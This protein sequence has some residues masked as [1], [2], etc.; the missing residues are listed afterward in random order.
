MAVRLS[1]GSRRKDHRGDLR[2]T[3][4]R[5]LQSVFGM[6]SAEIENSRV[7]DLFAGVGSYGIMAL[8]QGAALSVFVDISH[9]SE[10][11]MTRA[12]EKFHFEDRAFVF[13]ED[14]FHFLH[15]TDRQIEPFDVVFVDPPYAEFTPAR[16][17]E[18]VLDSGALAVGGLLVYEHSRHNAPPIVPPLVLRKSRIFGETTVSIWDMP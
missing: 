8:R 16:V 9:E 10:K 11:R 4:A 1:S 5:T 3:A 2:P 6:L 15:K 17:I 7:L 14:V 12:I 13:R 18:E